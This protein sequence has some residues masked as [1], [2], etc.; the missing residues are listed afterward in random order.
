MAKRSQDQANSMPWAEEIRMLKT[1]HV[2]FAREPHQKCQS[3]SFPDASRDASDQPPP[4][5]P[6]SLTFPSKYGERNPQNEDIH[7]KVGLDYTQIK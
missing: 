3:F 6:A 5:P 7:L 1:N 4:Q 2:Q